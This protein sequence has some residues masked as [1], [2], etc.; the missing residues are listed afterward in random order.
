MVL[1]ALA[2]LGLPVRTGTKTTSVVAM[3]EGA[4]PGPTMLLRADMDALPL[5]EDTG[6]SF[7]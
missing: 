1:E 5:Q 3:L 7:A 6:L 4:R 2:P